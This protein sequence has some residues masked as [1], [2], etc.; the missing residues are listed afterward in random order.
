MP[1]RDHSLK[2]RPREVKMRLAEQTLSRLEE[3]NIWLATWLRFL[4]FGGC[5]SAQPWSVCTTATLD[6]GCPVTLE[7][8]IPTRSARYFVYRPTNSQSQK[9]G[10]GGRFEI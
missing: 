9:P 3:P 4:R 6:D 2:S 7:A 5:T 10:V 1:G 8:S